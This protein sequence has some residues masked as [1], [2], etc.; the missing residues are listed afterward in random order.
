MLALPLAMECLAAII[1]FKKINFFFKLLKQP[2]IKFGPIPSIPHT[3][4]NSIWVSSLSAEWL[5]LYSM[6]F[7]IYHH[8][9]NQ[10]KLF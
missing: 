10:D 5:N 3:E 2:F 4:C 8:F 6:L 9:C 7:D 1:A